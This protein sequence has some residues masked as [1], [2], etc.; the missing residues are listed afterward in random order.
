MD[1]RQVRS[2]AVFRALQLGDMLCSIPAL[3][4]LRGG[5]PAARISLVGLPSAAHLLDRYP[6]L[7]DE[8]LRFP[9]A[10]GMPEQRANPGELGR[11]VADARSRR[12]DLVIQLHGSGELTN[13]IVARLGARF[14]AGF[15]PAGTPA[16]RGFV[17]WPEALPEPLR[18]LRVTRALGIPDDGPAFDF[19]LHAADRVEASA[20]LAEDGLAAGEYICLHAGARLASRRWPLVH[21]ARVG[22]MLASRGWPLVLTGTREERVLVGELDHALR[23]DGVPRALVHRVDGR[24]SLGG[25]AA[26]V[27]GSRLL[28]ANDT[29]VSHIAAGLRHPSV[30]VAS[31]SDVRRWAP[32]DAGRHRVLWADAPCRPCA[33]DHCP[34][35]HAC[36]WDV[37][38]AAV[39]AAIDEQLERH[40]HA[41]H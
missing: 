35:G 25:M 22:R 2:I 41:A 4:A 6:G 15:V 11:F 32:L 16:P 30:I 39:L 3:R 20:L 27:G 21:F 7:V 13:R 14:L 29:G 28:L 38:P 37:A 24:T 8:L 1:K 5:F 34:H 36:A 26:I 23:A 17:P 31:G 9:G 10:P 19:P 40:A 33:F 12:F 18:Y